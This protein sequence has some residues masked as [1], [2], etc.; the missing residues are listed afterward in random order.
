MK[1]VEIPAGS[2][3]E[4]QYTAHSK[5]ITYK[6]SYNLVRG[7]LAEPNPES[8]TV[9]SDEI[10]LKN[11]ALEKY[12]FTGW[13]GTGLT[14]P[15]MEVKISRGSMGDRSYQAT[16]K[17]DDPS[18]KIADMA[19]EAVSGGFESRIEDLPELGEEAELDA[20]VLEAVREAL[21]NALHEDE[22]ISA[23]LDAISMTVVQEEEPEME[24]RFYRYLYRVTVTYKDDAGTEYVRENTAYE[25]WI[26]KNQPEV[27]LAP[28]A[29]SLT[30]G[31]SLKD[32]TLTGG[33]VKYGEVE[34]PGT[35]SWQ[36]ETIIPWGGDNGSVIYWVIF[37]PDEEA[38][39][40]YAPCEIEV[41][42]QTQIG[43]NVEFTAD[44]RDY[45]KD[46]TAATGTYRLVDADRGIVYEEL[47]LTGGQMEF[48]QSVPGKEL[49]VVFA[50][51]QLENDEDGLYILLNESAKSEA[52]IRWIQPVLET[53]PT[54]NGT[55]T[56]G[57]ALRD[58]EVTG[59]RAVYKVAANAYQEAAGTWTWDTPGHTLS[60]EGEQEFTL[61]FVPEDEDGFRRITGIEVKLTVTKREVEIPLIAGLTYDGSLQ[62]PVVN[63]TADY[64]VTENNGGISA[65]T[66][67]VTLRLKY[68]E[69]MVWK[70]SGL[71]TDGSQ[72]TVSSEDPAVAVVSYQIRKA[73]LTVSA[74]PAGNGIQVQKLGYGQEMTEGEKETRTVNGKVVDFRLSAQD[75][76]SGVVVS[77]ERNGSSIPVTGKW[78]WM[79]TDE[80]GEPYNSQPMQVGTWQIEAEFIPE[81]NQRGNLNPVSYRF[82]VKVEKAVPDASSCA[83]E[84]I[85]VIGLGALNVPLTLCKL[86]QPQPVNPNNGETVNGVWNWEDPEMILNSRSYNVTFTPTDSK[87]YKTVNSSAEV[88]AK[89]A[90][91]L[92]AYVKY[93]SDGTFTAR[94][95]VSIWGTTRK[96]SILVGVSEQ[97]NM[98]FSEVKIL[99][100]NETASCRVDASGNY[101]Y[102]N[103]GFMTVIYHSSLKI[104]EIV[105]ERALTAEPTIDVYMTQT[106][107]TQSLEA[108]ETKTAAVST[109]SRKG[110]KAR[111]KP[112]KTAE[113][114]SETAAAETEAVTE[115]Q[116][117]APEPSTEEVT[118]PTTE[119][120]TEKTTEAGTE[121]PE[122]E[123]QTETPATEETTEAAEPA[124]E[125]QTAAP[126]PASEPSTEPQTEKQTET[127]APEPSTEPQTEAAAEPQT[128]AILPEP[129]TEPMTEA[130]EPATEAQTELA[131]ELQSESL[132]T[133]AMNTEG[134]EMPLPEEG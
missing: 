91:P 68:P 84:T 92:T 94:T 107:G 12:E 93:G 95:A 109:T 47:K 30:Y 31:Q 45:V 42:V 106:T 36:D 6:L 96:R 127:A 54:V 100:G 116:T 26:S 43:V 2:S 73:D 4:R 134:A 102:T 37:T 15:T 74:N 28:T 7:T 131:S 80:K 11:P 113:S 52:E 77:Y 110:K 117:E 27:T 90:L 111:R 126:E 99:M 121:A 13:I 14:E 128:E 57:T 124:T 48:S 9:E 129:A 39:K 62:K 71:A 58:V 123:K 16:W 41:S 56:G 61:T 108:D 115:P 24:D 70:E 132:Q 60:G 55:V 22:R 10:T 21:Q 53:A 8:Y 67:T 122:P 72:A 87:N 81:E 20:R 133:E 17:T 82:Q 86:D 32:S 103:S 35:F 88:K 98:T 130:P 1:T 3:G 18:E 65:G 19:L 125:S 79:L 83:F 59:G 75:M 120:V 25:A 29:G 50:G 23:Y 105:M 5:A 78:K 69:Y 119:P 46:S 51:Y 44:S 40:L 97:E 112:E 38:A 64:E 85:Y 104:V 49:Q 89:D 118:E 76:I 34:V 63:E 114:E 66:Y 101:V 33:C